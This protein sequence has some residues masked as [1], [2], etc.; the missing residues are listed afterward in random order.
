M[1]EKELFLKS[2]EEKLKNNLDRKALKNLSKGKKFDD[3]DELN[4]SDYEQFRL[5]SIPRS[6]NLYEKVCNFSEK[7]LNIKPDSKTEK[8][9][10]ELLYKAH[11][12]C[13]PTGVISASIF[14]SL[15][16]VLFGFFTIAVTKSYFIGGGIILLGLTLY[17]IMQGVPSLL[18]KKLKSKANDEIIISIFYIVA[19]MRFNSNFEL[20]VNFAANYLNPPLSLDFKRL[21]WELDNSKY[22]NIK[23]G[24]DKYLE[25]WRDENLEFLEAIYMIESSLYESEEFRRLSLLDKALDVILRGN[26][27]K[28]IHFAQDLRGKV[29]TFNMIGVVLPILGLII[30]PLAASF[31]NPKS[32]W[33]IVFLLY[34]IIFPAGVAY[35]AFLIAFNRPSSVNS[36]KSPTNIKNFKKMQKMPIKLS[37][38][39]TI[40][41]PPLIPGL[42]IFLIFSLIGFSPILLHLTGGDEILNKVISSMVTNKDYSD[43]FGIFQEYKSIIRDNGNINYVYGPYGFYPGLLSLFIPLAIAFGLGYYLR[44]KYRELIHVRDKT[45]NLEIQFPSATFQL[46]NRINE[47]ISAELAFGAVA[48]TM[49]GTEAGEFFSIIDRNIKFNGMSIKNSIFDESK[50]AIINYPSDLVISSMKI[51]VNAIDRGPEITAK[52]LIDLSKYL[53]DIHMSN[54]RLMDLLAESLGSM[55]GQAN[56]LA[57][58]ISGIVISIVSLVTTIMGKLS[59]A[60]AELG[61]SDLGAASASSFLG[62]SI[63]TYLFQSVVGIYIV[64]LIAILMYL[65]TNLENGEDPILMKYSIGEK[66]IKGITKYS[67]VVCLGIFL[68]TFIAANLTL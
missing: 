33:E 6:A 31:G 38:K 56:F 36:I 62:D 28:M 8:K 44:Y 49:K 24:F 29:S 51:L 35:F 57:P 21:L 7:I 18:A 50:G 14:I 20:A 5:E 64:M 47:G 63:P 60:T 61:N 67:I 3:D 10:D 4:T 59:K 12:G 13:T 9:I 25:G 68:F 34:N 26:Y 46:G 1:D 45:K 48:E 54:E 39:K 66:M 15:M 52:T 32:V 30:L 53:T 11:L 41:L 37:K 2:F 65:V 43:T 27:E 58:I 55:K 19:Y 40:Y 42:V 17:L 22:P 23:D 16:V